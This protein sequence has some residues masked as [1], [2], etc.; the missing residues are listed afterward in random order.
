MDSSS[1]IQHFDVP[2]LQT[3]STDTSICLLAV[4]C[5]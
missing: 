5:N 1:F 2:A 4:S 3:E